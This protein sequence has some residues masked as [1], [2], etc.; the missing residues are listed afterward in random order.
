MVSVLLYTLR[1]TSSDLDCYP[2]AL[3]FL[4]HDV[5]AQVACAAPG[6]VAVTW[7]LQ[8]YPPDFVFHR[9][10]AEMLLVSHPVGDLA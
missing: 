1:L 2:V 5:I 4:P 6:V 10:E 3:V 9:P 8:E 7:S